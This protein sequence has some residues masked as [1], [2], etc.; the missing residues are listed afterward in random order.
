MTFDLD[1]TFDLINKW[2]FPCC[3]YDPTLVEINQSMWKIEPNVNPFFTTDNIQQQPTKWSLYVFP[4][5]VG[6]TNI[7]PL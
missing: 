4:A 6:N 2:E 7:I 1:M 3:I 5:K